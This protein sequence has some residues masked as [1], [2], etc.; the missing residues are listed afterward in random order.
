MSLK[1]SSL[2]SDC[3]KGSGKPLTCY[4]GKY[5]SYSGHCNNV[6]FANWG[7]AN[8]AFARWLAP[9]YA[10]G[11]SSPRVSVHSGGSALPSARAISLAI[12]Q[13]QESPFS[14][15]TTLNTFFGKFVLKISSKLNEPFKCLPF[16]VNSF[17]TTLPTLPSQWASEDREF[18]VVKL[19]LISFTRNVYQ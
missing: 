18:G 3:P 2:L 4:P 19:H 12:H 8:S 5:R 11:V 10:D 15:M 6:E 1:G 13:G 9:R 7:S 14:H 17:S 16:Q